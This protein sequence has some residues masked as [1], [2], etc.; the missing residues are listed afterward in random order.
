MAVVERAWCA[1]FFLVA[2][3]APASHPSPPATPTAVADRCPNEPEDEDGFQDDDGCRDPDNDQDRILDGDDKC[4]NEP[5]IY[6]G[7]EDD[8]GCPDRDCVIQKPSASECKTEP[9][10]FDRG[11]DQPAIARYGTLL[12]F[13]AE[14]IKQS[15]DD[16]QI[17]ELRGFRSRDEARALSKQRA[18][19]VAQ[20]LIARGV[21][22]SRLSIVDGGVAAP[23]DAAHGLHLV[24]LSIAQQGTTMEDADDIL[25]TPMGPWFR[26]LTDAQRAAR[27]RGH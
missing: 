27:C 12:D 23:M 11:K 14:Y 4:P 20:L 7:F 10:L 1:L 6:N 17:V 3:S 25:C 5:E 8:D 22:E 16:I 24:E 13:A 18:A 15:D 21:D 19:A 2:C 26:H 9:I